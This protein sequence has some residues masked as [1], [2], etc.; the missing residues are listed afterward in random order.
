MNQSIF[1]TLSGPLPDH[2]KFQDRPYLV[3]TSIEV[4]FDKTVTIDPGV[5]FLFKNFSGLHIRGRLIAKGTADK[6]IVFTS[7]FDKKYNVNAD[8]DANPY[9]W[10]GI[11]LTSDAFGSKLEHCQISYTVYGLTSDTKF[12]RLDP[13]YFIDNGRSFI[14]IENTQIPVQDSLFQYILDKAETSVESVLPPLLK[15]PLA[16]KRAFL[17]IGSIMVIT[18]GIVT[19]GYNAGKW[20]HA[21][22]DYKNA[23]SKDIDNLRRDKG[24]EF[25]NKT[26]KTRNKYIIYTGSCSLIAAIGAVGFKWSFTF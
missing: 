6:P 4:P 3:T 11:Y 15:D 24:T 9:D 10:D 17:R 20:Y 12:L 19:T 8:H 22:H 1:D 14:T 2:V 26:K 16:N 13:V 23:S 25:W 7:E 21:Q 5:I 18:G